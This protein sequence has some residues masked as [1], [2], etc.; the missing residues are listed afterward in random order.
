MGKKKDNGDGQ[1]ID[2]TAWMVTF[3]DLVTLLMTFFVLLLS[4]KAMDTKTLQSMFSIFEGGVGVMEFSDLA[5]VKP[6]DQTE[7]VVGLEQG[8]L[9]V[10]QALSSRLDRLFALNQKNDVES[11]GELEEM[12]GLGGDG[13]DTAGLGAL[14]SVVDVSEDERGVV[15][16]L[17]AGVLF[18]P[19][20]AEIRQDMYP[21]LDMVA[22]VLEVV[23]NEILVMGHTDDKPL[24]IGRFRSNWELSLHRA[25]NVHRYFIQEKNLSPERCFAGGYGDLR[26]RNSNETVE[27]REK[28]R[29]VEIVLRRM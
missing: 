9:S 13:D 14:Q 19:G 2:T 28:N 1:S 12:L 5:G 10:L 25:L 29:R 11:S 18:A 7:S 24:R 3:G 8:A 4:M 21:V 26:P 20:K 16:V 6:V 17:E 22:K 23:K 15:I 27:G